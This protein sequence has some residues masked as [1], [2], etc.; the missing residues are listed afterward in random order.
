M[1]CPLCIC[2]RGWEDCGWD[3]SLPA[4]YGG[5]DING[6]MAYSEETNKSLG[7]GTAFV[8][9]CPDWHSAQLFKEWRRYA[10]MSFKGSEAP[11]PFYIC[12]V[13]ILV[14]DEV[15]TT[16]T[17]RSKTIKT[18]IPIRTK[19]N[20]CPKT[21]AVTLADGYQAKVVQIML[22][23]YCITHIRESYYDYLKP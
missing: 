11:F 2:T 23:E 6:P 9:F 16:K 21:P 14:L 12:G 8:K 5:Q 20:G 17:D 3:V 19:S 22:R 1:C 13:I 18:P 15:E 4:V 10:K 7:N